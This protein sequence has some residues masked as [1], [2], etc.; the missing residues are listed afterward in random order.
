MKRLAG[1]ALASASTVFPAVLPAV[2]PLLAHA[3]DMNAVNHA[4]QIASGVGAG[5]DKATRIRSV[6]IC[7]A[8]PKAPSGTRTADP[9][10]LR[11]T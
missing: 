4:A 9:F 3:A 1:R 8:A 11:I 6:Q 5:T 10:H 2:F 7:I